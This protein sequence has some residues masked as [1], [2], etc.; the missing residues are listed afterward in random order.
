MIQVECLTTTTTTRHF[1]SC[2]ALSVTLFVETLAV[3]MDVERGAAWRRRQRRLRS[4][5]RYEQRTVA[6]VLAAVTHH[7]HSTVGTANAAL[8]GQ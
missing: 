7:S 4:W 1:G 6:A 8:R 5:W 3:D 2:V